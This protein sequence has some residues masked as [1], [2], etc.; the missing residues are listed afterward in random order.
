MNPLD[1]IY[2]WQALLLAAAAT[3]IT[4]LVKTSFDVA[5]GGKQPSMSDAKKAG[6][7]QRRKSVILNR[8]VLPM[9]PILVGFLFAMVVPVRPE[10]LIE[11]VAEHVSEVWQQYLVYGSWGAACGQF[12]SYTYDKVREALMKKEDR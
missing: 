7:E 2:S 11:Y 9:T 8:F 10:A 5:K 1:L 3:G 6:E 4:Q 12:S